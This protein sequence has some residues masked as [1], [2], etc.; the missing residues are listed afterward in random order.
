MNIWE[1]ASVKRLFEII[2]QLETE[3]ECRLFFEDLCTVREVQDMA[4]RLEVAELL[5][6]R[7]N[8]QE[9]SATTAVSSA[10]ISRVNRC[11]LYG[12]GGYRMALEKNDAEEKK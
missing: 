7:K 4:Q 10:T 6:A 5:R 2:T 3:E 1:S 12:H 11:L 9:I 8:Y